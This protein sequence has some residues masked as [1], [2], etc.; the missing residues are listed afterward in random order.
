MPRYHFDLAD[1]T[2]VEDKGGQVLADDTTASDVADEIARRVYQARSELRGK[3]YCIIVTDV[4][5]EEI[6]RA[7]V[8]P[9]VL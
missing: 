2:T 5:G 7:P 9:L 4:D 1:H 6:Y 8:L 3:G